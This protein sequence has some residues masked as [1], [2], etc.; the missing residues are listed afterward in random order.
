VRCFSTAEFGGQRG[1]GT[2]FETTASGKEVMLYSFKGTPK[3]GANPFGDLIA[4]K[5]ILYGTT[6][7]GGI[8]VGGQNHPDAGSTFSFTP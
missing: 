3:D 8:D 5:G 2:I 1:F 6:V 7:N 4:F